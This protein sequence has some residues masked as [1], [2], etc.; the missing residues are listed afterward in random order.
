MTIGEFPNPTIKIDGQEIETVD[1][2]TNLG[3]I[4]DV[5]G[6][7]DA[8]VQSRINKARHAFAVLKPIWKSRIITFRTK[9]R[10]FNTNVKS[11]L[12]YGSECWNILYI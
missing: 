6:G 2:F 3:S 4:V 9:I 8:D 10:V 1:G 7:A 5:N 12:L 11:L